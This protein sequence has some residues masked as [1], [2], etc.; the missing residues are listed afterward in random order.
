[1]PVYFDL[2]IVPVFLA[3]HS[4]LFRRKRFI[5]H[6]GFMRVHSIHH[7]PYP[8]GVAIMAGNLLRCKPARNRRKFFLLWWKNTGGCGNSFVSLNPSGSD[9]CFTFFLGS[10]IFYLVEIFLPHTIHV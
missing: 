9:G 5:K 1:L 10:K 7:Q 4:P 3:K 2:S 8:V 6:T